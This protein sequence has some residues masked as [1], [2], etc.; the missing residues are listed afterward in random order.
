MLSQFVV[1][2]EAG[3]TAGTASLR[4]VVDSVQMLLEARDGAVVAG[5]AIAVILFMDVDVRISIGIVLGIRTRE[6]LSFDCI[7]LD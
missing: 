2:R 7:L 4:S 1:I 3:P 5:R 6:E